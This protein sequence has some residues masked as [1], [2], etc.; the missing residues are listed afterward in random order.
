LHATAR[1][2][3]HG[4][5][6]TTAAHWRTRRDFEL[7]LEID[8]DIHQNPEH[9]MLMVSSLLGQSGNSI[10]SH[11]HPGAAGQRHDPVGRRSSNQFHEAEP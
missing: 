10:R 1:E 6:N 7:I 4:Y 8:I 9:D 11:I 2:P 5:F 3:G